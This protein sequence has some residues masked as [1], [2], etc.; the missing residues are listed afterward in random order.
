MSLYL[1]PFNDTDYFSAVFCIP[2]AFR[3]HPE[4]RP[5]SGE[6][7]EAQRRLHAVLQRSCLHQ[8]DRGRE[9]GEE[10]NLKKALNRLTLSHC[11]CLC[12]RVSLITYY[13]LY[14]NKIILVFL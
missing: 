4:P 3:K 5:S 14:Y 2:V 6:R 13:S 7:G 12:E 1:H 8:E 9:G 11:H 10:A